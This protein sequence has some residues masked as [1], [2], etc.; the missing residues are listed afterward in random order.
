MNRIESQLWTP[1]FAGVTL[2]FSKPSS[3]RVH[4]RKEFPRASRFRLGALLACVVV[5]NT[6]CAGRSGE[7]LTPSISC[8]LGDSALV[9]DV[10]YF[11]RNKPVG[12]SVSD[13]EWQSFLTEV[14]TPRFPDGLTVVEGTG[15]WKGK[16]GVVERERSEVVTLLHNGKRAKRQAVVELIAEYKRRFQ[17]EAVLHERMGTCAHF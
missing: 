13:A 15:Q 3:S 4:P 10:V 6:G 14:V 7:R 17:Q 16:N 8:E 2:T 5:A 12:G 1:A 9:R 11:G